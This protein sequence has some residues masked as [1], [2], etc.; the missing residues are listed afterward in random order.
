M[1][2]IRSEY[3]PLRATK[4]L[5]PQ[6][7]KHAFTKFSPHNRCICEEISSNPG[8]CQFKSG[9]LPPDNFSRRGKHDA[10]ALVRRASNERM[11]CRRQGKTCLQ[12]N[13][14]LRVAANALAAAFWSSRGQSMFPQQISVEKG[15]ALPLADSSATG[16]SGVRQPHRPRQAS[17]LKLVGQRPSPRQLSNYR[18]R[19]DWSWERNF[20]GNISSAGAQRMRS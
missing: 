16:I 7:Q 9:R 8:G 11:Q 10:Y 18:P 6:K 19:G 3:L 14:S 4:H 12:R 20:S 5:F 1:I 13:R 17:L 2:E 15:S